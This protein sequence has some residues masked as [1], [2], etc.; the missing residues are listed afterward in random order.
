MTT[1][2]SPTSSTQDGRPHVDLRMPGAIQTEFGLLGQLGETSSPTA[3]R[4]EHFHSSDPQT[5]QRFFRSAYTPRWHLTGL[6]RGSA[7]THRRCEVEGMTVDELLIEGRVGFEIPVADSVVVIQPRAG[8]LTVTGEPSTSADSPILIADGLPCALHATAARFHV[9]TIH[10][11]LLRKVAAQRHV[12]AGPQIQFVSPRPRSRAGVLSW[13][14]ALDYVLTSY[15]SAETAQRPLMVNATAQ[16]VV[17]TVLECFPSNM[18][19]GRDLL[20][21]PAVPQA[22]KAAVLFIQEH[23]GDDISVNDIAS[24]ACLTPRAVQY[25]FRQQ[26]DATPTEYLRRV[27][28]FRAHLDLIDGERATTTVAA[29]ARRWGFAHTGR[30][31]VLYREVYGQSPHTTLRQ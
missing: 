3:L 19:A 16:L 12:S 18:T 8:S 25:L 6:V 14:R 26:V 20:S 9:V 2:T 17:A 7:V 23:A 10:S 11:K 31:A 4:F 28:L 30:F 1:V 27:R 24:E 5:T 22:F 15:G 13:H 29:V 21:N